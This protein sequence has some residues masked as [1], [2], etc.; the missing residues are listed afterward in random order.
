MT[1]GRP[2]SRQ[3]LQHNSPLSTTTHS[4]RNPPLSVFGVPS[5]FGNQGSP[6]LQGLATAILNGQSPSGIMVAPRGR[7]QQALPIADRFMP[8]LNDPPPPQPAQPNPQMSALHQAHLRDPM[9]VQ[10]PGTCDKSSTRCFYQ[11]VSYYLLP[12][13]RLASG[14]R[15]QEWK[16]DLHEGEYNHIALTTQSNIEGQRSTRILAEGSHQYRLRCSKMPKLVSQ[17]CLLC[18]VLASQNC[19]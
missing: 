1:A 18:A 10:T 16:F 7:G 4:P 5:V 9:L 19:R 15:V 11:M 6:T 13:K 12:P 17:L 8:A 3:P 2:S 14:A